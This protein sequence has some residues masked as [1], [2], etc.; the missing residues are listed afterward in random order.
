[1]HNL[2]RGRHNQKPSSLCFCLSIYSLFSLKWYLLNKF[3]FHTCDAV[4]HSFIT[5]W[6]WLINDVCITKQLTVF[7]FHTLMQIQFVSVYTFRG[8]RY[9]TQWTAYNKI[10]STFALHFFLFHWCA[11]S[12]NKCLL[13]PITCYWIVHL[14]IML[15]ALSVVMCYI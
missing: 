10:T 4:V 11:S 12:C 13:K 8:K 2:P 3:Y 1:M 5:V 14:I 15:F 9:W 6:S 7:I